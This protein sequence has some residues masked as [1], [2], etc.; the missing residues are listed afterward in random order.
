[1]SGN[2]PD[3]LEKNHYVL[4]DGREV[5]VSDYRFVSPNGGGPH[6]S[7]E[8]MI[9]VDGQEMEYDRKR[10]RPLP[11]AE[12]PAWLKKGVSVVFNSFGAKIQTKV[13]MVFGMR[14]RDEKKTETWVY[15]ES[16][17]PCAQKFDGRSIKP[18]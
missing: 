6:N 1:M 16:H 11:A 14:A 3:F 18:E 13:A 17:G 5:L 15:L 10:I 9:Y 4:L 12:A 7:D 8:L 2:V